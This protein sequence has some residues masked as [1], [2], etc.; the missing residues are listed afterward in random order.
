MGE[1]RK[2][3][4]LFK[5]LEQ[6]S[7]ITKMEQKHWKAG[8]YRKFEMLFQVLFSQSVKS[9]AGKPRQNFATGKH[10]YDTNIKDLITRF[11]VF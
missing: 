7:Q 5:E 2:K 10:S 9:S 1:K 6:K 11:S 8:A 3:W 4:I